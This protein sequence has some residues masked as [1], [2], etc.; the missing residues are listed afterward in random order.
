MTQ[1]VKLLVSITDIHQ[2]ESGNQTCGGYTGYTQAP[3]VSSM[4]LLPHRHPLPCQTR[5]TLLWRAHNPKNKRVIKERKGP[6]ESKAYEKNRHGMYLLDHD[7]EPTN[8]HYHSPLHTKL[9]HLH[10]E[11]HHHILAPTIQ[12]LLDMGFVSVS[13]TR[14][15]SRR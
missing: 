3:I 1:N 11:D 10:W 13:R 2:R 14:Q 6:T 15:D 7:P 12:G 8:L 5:T 4:V 9:N